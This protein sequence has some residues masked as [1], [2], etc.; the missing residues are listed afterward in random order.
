VRQIRSWLCCCGSSSSEADLA[1][2]PGS[3]AQS[4]GP[5]WM[6][7]EFVGVSDFQSSRTHQC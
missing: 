7:M 2:P 6:E 5:F 1:K 4:L 3:S